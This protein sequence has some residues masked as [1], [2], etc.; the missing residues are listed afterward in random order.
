LAKTGK[1]ARPATVESSTPDLSGRIEVF[2]L[3]EVFEML[4]SG[5]KSGAC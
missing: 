4:S 3:Y 5:R 2:S 1:I